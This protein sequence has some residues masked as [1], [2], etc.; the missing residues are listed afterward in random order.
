ML[1]NSFEF[2]TNFD[3]FKYKFDDLAEPCL[4]G[5]CKNACKPTVWL[6]DEVF[7]SFNNWNDVNTFLKKE[8]IYMIKH[9]E[10]FKKFKLYL[11]A[12]NKENYNK[13]KKFAPLDSDGDNIYKYIK[14]YIYDE[15]YIKN[16]I[17][18]IKIQCSKILKSQK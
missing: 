13:L 7:K 18:D 5:N 16:N 14:H 11:F 3:L 12:I 15:N 6:L 4:I 8:S 10:F 17:N 1:I 9:I 2:K